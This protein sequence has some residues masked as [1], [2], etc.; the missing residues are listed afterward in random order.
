MSTGP[1]NDPFSGS[2]TRNILQHVISPKIV[3]DGSGGYTV[4]TDLINIDNAY[5]GTQLFTDSLTVQDST[6]N[7]DKLVITTDTAK[8]YITTTTSA[9]A[10]SELIL[11][12]ADVEIKNPD[13]ADNGVL[14]LQTDTSGNGYV[15]AGQDGTGTERLY[16]GTQS[17]NTIVVMPS[18]YVGIGVSPPTATLDVNG[19]IIGTNLKRYT[20]TYTSYSGGAYTFS[21]CLIPINSPAC[22]NFIA[23][24]TT[25]SMH[26]GMIMV[27][28]A[29]NKTVINV[30]YNTA[31]TPSFSFDISGGNFILKQTVDMAPG[32]TNGF[33]I[34]IQQIS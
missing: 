8:S 15:R 34:I 21:S 19:T 1:G 9:G 31:N 26:G 10:R 20:Q 22:Y 24:T 2:N 7:S 25:G 28:L 27:G 12:G 6:T 18:G 23:Y 29:S 32:E 11:S 16:L 4:K 33:A 17:T 14:I 5:I 13:N 30:Y 3:N